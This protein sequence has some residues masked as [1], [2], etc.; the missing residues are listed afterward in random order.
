[1]FQVVSDLQLTHYRAI[2]VPNL[3]LPPAVPNA[4][5]ASLRLCLPQQPPAP[6]Q[7]ISP[8]CHESEGPLAGASCMVALPWPLLHLPCACPPNP[9]SCACPAYLLSLFVV[10]QGSLSSRSFMLC[11]I[12]VAN[13]CPFQPV[14]SSPQPAPS[15]DHSP[16]GP[17][18]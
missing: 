17:T 9:G 15:S 3:P 6:M 13:N 2:E 11:L 4:H 8:H 18:V 14:L 7:A 16:P 12:H 5:S 10:F 1:M